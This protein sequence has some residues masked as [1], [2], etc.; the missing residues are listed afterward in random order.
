VGLGI[1][2]FFFNVDQ[3]GLHG[4]LPDKGADFQWEE[5]E[6]SED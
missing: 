3:A 4:E 5:R 6:E 2:G 1:Y